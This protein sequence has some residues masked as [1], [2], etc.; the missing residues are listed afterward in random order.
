MAESENKNKF[1]T[2]VNALFEGMNRFA[3]TKT[4]VGEPVRFEDGTI[5]VPLIDVSFG[6]GAGAF[7]DGKN[8]GGGIGGKISANSIL[9]LK[10]GSS[11]LV[12]VK[13]QD[14]ITKLVDM[15]P[16]LVNRFVKTD[17]AKTGK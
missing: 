9:V 2:T 15:V 5:L 1:D 10:D 16:D 6:M 7:S 13:A 4:V 8:Q 3:T 14:G 12:S 17:S 11:K